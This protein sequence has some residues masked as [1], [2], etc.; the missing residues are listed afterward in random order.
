MKYQYSGRRE[1]LSQPISGA[2]LD[3]SACETANRLQVLILGKN[4]GTDSFC[5][6]LAANVQRWGYEAVIVTAAMMGDSQIWQGIE[7]DILLYDMDALFQHSDVL[8]NASVEWASTLNIDLVARPPDWPKAR[9]KMIL[10]SSSVSRHTLELLGAIAW[11]HKPFDMRV[12]ERYLRVFQQLLYPEAESEEA[13]VLSGSSLTTMGRGA[14]CTEGSGEV[15]R[16]AR[17][18]IADDR[19]EVTWGI[20]QCLLE[21]EN[22][23]YHY[24][25]REGYE[26]LALLEQCLIW[27]PHC[28]VTDVLMPW[29]NGYQVMRCLASVKSQSKPVFVVISALMKHEIPVDR[30]YLQDLVV[31]Y[32]EKPFDVEDLL[33]VIEQG[34][35]RRSS[36]DLGARG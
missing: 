1:D 2:E 23:R 19:E 17:I 16:I 22:Q 27:K 15:V 12:L 25:V 18:L 21:Q 8:G 31:R 13:S 6:I 7:G 33:N 20:R 26:G 11:L 3:V 34:L 36:Q 30:S 4:G 9:L 14:G 10:S 5:D 28:V 29:L 32:I 24:E 35:T